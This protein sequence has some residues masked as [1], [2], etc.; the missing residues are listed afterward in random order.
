MEPNITMHHSGD[1]R[2]K[3]RSVL[4]PR[5]GPRLLTCFIII[6]NH[7]YC[8]HYVANAL[9]VYVVRTISGGNCLLCLM[10]ATPIINIAHCSHEGS[11]RAP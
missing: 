3:D 1:S 8:C 10:L 6:I 4:R 11:A 7:Y 2:T 5:R 9:Y